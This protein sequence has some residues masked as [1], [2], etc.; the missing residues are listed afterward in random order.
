MN[1]GFNMN[2]AMISGDAGSAFM[3]AANLPLPTLPLPL[4][5]GTA[6]RGLMNGDGGSVG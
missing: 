5:A 6:A 2:D 1:N 4:L 3:R